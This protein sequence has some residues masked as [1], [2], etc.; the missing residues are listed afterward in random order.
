MFFNNTS[1]YTIF[2]KPKHKPPKPIPSPSPTNISHIV[3]GIAGSTK[4]YQ[5]RASYIQS[6]WKPNKTR[7]FIFFETLPNN[8]LPWSNSSPPFHISENTSKYDDYNKHPIPQ[9]IRMARIVYE[10]F[11]LIK[12]NVRWYVLADDDTI[13]FM[14]NLVDVLGR[15]DHEKYFYIGMI[16]ECHASNF[17]HSFEMGF[18]G[19]GFA[20]SYPLAKALV[21]K[22]DLCLKRYPSLYGSDHIVQSCVADLGVSLTQEK[23][24]HQIDL[25]NDISGL[26]SSHPH[27]PF[28]SLHHLDVVDPIFPSM[29]RTQSLSH[30]MKSAKADESRLLQQTICYHKPK[31][32]TFS[33]SWGYSVQ[34]YEAIFP[35]SLLQ[36]P[37]QTFTPWSKSTKPFFVFNTRIPSNNPCENPHVFFFDSVGNK[38][39]DYIVTRYE[40]KRYRGLPACSLSGNHSADFVSGI[41]VLSPERKYDLIG[42]RRE[43]CDVL[44]DMRRNATEIKLRDCFEN[45]IL[46]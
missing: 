30:L 5:N 6:W 15:Y 11:N 36:K 14:N 12:D 38:R 42:N 24:F 26:L 34:I 13:F 39:G 18:G 22:L 19:A 33:I 9:A 3:F 2:T 31:N 17:Y 20:L 8:H 25:H 41:V 4:T 43:C 40:R 45:E 23:G 10:M 21:K 37:L 1:N 46:P 27:S 35:P 29:N 28:L 16:S 7:G 32:W 44:H